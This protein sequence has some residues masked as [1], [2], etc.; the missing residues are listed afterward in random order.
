MDIR[1][2]FGSIDEYCK[3]VEKLY[4][5]GYEE[6]YRRGY[7][8]AVWNVINAFEE[9]GKFLEETSIEELME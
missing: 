5:A 1:Q 2:A 3:Q 4:D 7:K 8:D 6:G 9:E